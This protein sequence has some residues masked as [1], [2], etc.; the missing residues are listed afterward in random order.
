MKLPGRIDGPLAQRALEAAHRGVGEVIVRGAH[1]GREYVGDPDAMA[2]NKICIEDRTVT[3]W[4]IIRR[5]ER[6]RLW[7]LGPR[8]G[9]VAAPTFTRSW[10]RAAS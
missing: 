10:S 4:V 5:D 6:G 1:V 2:T 8:G 9:T 3:G 7:L